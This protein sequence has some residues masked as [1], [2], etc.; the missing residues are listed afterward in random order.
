[1]HSGGILLLRQTDTRERT[2]KPLAMKT[3][4]PILITL[5]AA[6]TRTVY[7]PQVSYHRETDTLLM[8]VADSSLVRALL[9]CDSNNQV[10]MRQLTQTSGHDSRQEIAIDSGMMEVKTRWRTKYVERVRELRDTVTVVE[11]RESVR[12]ERYVPRIYR[13]AMAVA[14]A[15][16]ALAAIRFIRP[17]LK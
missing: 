8:E 13:I 16:V 1:M 15:S 3:A 12:R 17:R 11:V 4:L 10:V 5:L 6:C 9:E 14:A 7:V 2:I